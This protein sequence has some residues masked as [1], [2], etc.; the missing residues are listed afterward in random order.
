[1]GLGCTFRFQLLQGFRGSDT[2][3]RLPHY[4]MAVA[5]SSSLPPPSAVV[6]NSGLDAGP[7]ERSAPTGTDPV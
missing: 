3:P 4:R 1:M 6:G 5:F 7:P 2:R